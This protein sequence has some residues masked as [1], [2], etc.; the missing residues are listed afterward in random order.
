MRFGPAASSSDDG[1]GG[2]GM[3]T[4][5]EDVSGVTNGPAIE[6]EVGEVVAGGTAG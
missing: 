3:T 1:A 4:F 2:R 6:N 5:S